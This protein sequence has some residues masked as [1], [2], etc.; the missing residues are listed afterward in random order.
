M[1]FPDKRCSKRQKYDKVVAVWM[2]MGA[3]AILGAPWWVV[4]GAVLL[5][6]LSDNSDLTQDTTK[7]F[8]FKVAYSAAHSKSIRDHGSTMLR[9]SRRNRCTTLNKSTADVRTEFLRIAI[10][11]GKQ[12]DALEVVGHDTDMHVLPKR[13]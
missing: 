5:L 11:Q 9:L 6:L 7:G 10:H 3:T 1:S 4:T 2:S 13:T 12:P 8:A